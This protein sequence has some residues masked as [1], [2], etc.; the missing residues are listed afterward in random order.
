MVKTIPFYQIA[1]Q[2]TESN[3]ALLSDLSLPFM[4][5]Y[6]ADYATYDRLFLNLYR[7]FYYYSHKD[8]IVDTMTDFIADVKSLLTVN[9]KKYDELFRLEN[10]DD[11][12][13][14]ILDNYDMTETMERLTANKRTENIGERNDST[15]YG[16]MNNTVTTNTPEITTMRKNDVSAFDEESY[17][18]REQTTET[19]NNHAIDTVGQTEAHTDST[20]QGAQENNITDS[21]NENY[22]LH[23]KGNIGVMTQSDVLLKHLE[24]WD[25]YTFY[26]K[27]FA[28]VADVLLY[29]DV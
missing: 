28:D 7:T 14:N 3:K 24:L 21:G 16:E 19:T 5:K 13:Y 23:R 8:T 27:I 9:Q 20:T 1:V 15:N 25:G 26:Q 11:E 4:A 18:P 29:A 2:A 6:T 12:V 10:L 17:T 22:S